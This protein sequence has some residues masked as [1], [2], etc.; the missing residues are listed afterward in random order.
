MSE[1]QP[2]DDKGRFAPGQTI[3]PEHRAK[4]Q[5]AK[6]AKMGLTADLLESVGLTIDT[7]PTDLLVIA[8]KAAGGD[9]PAMRLFLSQTKQLER[10]SKAATSTKGE[11]YNI[12]L[13][14]ESVEYLVEHGVEFT[15]CEKCDT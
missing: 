12:V 10:A 3:T 6:E 1:E 15:L 9:M 7:A 11:V 14:Q 13:S 4:M 8:K 2:R 5:A